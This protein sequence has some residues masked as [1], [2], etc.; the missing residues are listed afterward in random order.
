MLTKEY[1]LE[2]ILERKAGRAIEI[3]KIPISGVRQRYQN[4]LESDEKM[5]EYFLEMGD[6]LFKYCNSFLTRPVF[7]F[8]YSRIG[9]VRFKRQFH[10]GGE[11]RGFIDAVLDYYMYISS[12][13]AWPLEIAEVT[14]DKVVVY[15][16]RCTVKCDNHLK[17]CM[18]TTSMEPRLSEM[19]WFGAKITYTE[20]IPNGDNRCKVI[21]ERK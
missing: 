9:P 1:L 14:E 7:H 13:G 17:L 6:F 10:L 3:D 11:P 5:R 15:F 20:R 4:K 12:Y 21:L 16:D 8:L 18:A 19:P 2:K